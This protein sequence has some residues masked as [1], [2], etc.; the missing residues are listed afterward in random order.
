M[1]VIG[2]ASRGT[3]LCEVSHTEIE[4]FMGL[5]YNNMKELKVGDNV[6]LGK[7]YNFASETKEAMLKTEAF[8]SSNKKIVEAI[9][10]GV[11]VVRQM[12]EVE[13]AQRG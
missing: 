9:L 10:N 3:Y 11:S 13:E 6:D 7:G 5:Y 8:I 2:I 4:K 1:K 12:P